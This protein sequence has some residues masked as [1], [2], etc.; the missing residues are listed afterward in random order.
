[1]CRPIDELVQRFRRLPD[2]EIHQDPII[3]V[4]A[5]SSGVARLSL[6]APHE[7]LSAIGQGV[8]LIQAIHKPGELG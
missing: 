8:D 2:R 7:S 6:E 1:V 3:V 5:E 4:R